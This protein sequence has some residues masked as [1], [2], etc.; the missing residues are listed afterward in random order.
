MATY[1]YGIVP[2]RG[3]VAFEAEFDEG[4]WKAIATK[5]YDDA[6]NNAAALL[7]A[8]LPVVWKQRMRWSIA[9]VVAALGAPSLAELDQGWDAA[10]RRL[11]HRIAI[12]VDDGERAVRDA[13]DRLRSQLLAGS[14]TAQTQLDLDGEVDFGRQQIALTQ[15][16]GP[17]AA[18]VKKL[19]LGEALAEVAKATEALAK[20]LGRAAGTK[21][22]PPS[23][24]LRDAV[25]ECAAAFNAVH[26]ELVWF[27]GRTPPGT[28]RDT[29]TALI[30]PLEDLLAR[31]SPATSPAAEPS[32]PAAPAAP[33]E[34]GTQPA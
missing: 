14:G 13:A 18:D 26:D 8:P 10:Q 30:K 12:G 25:A 21:R 33:A 2:D 28:D 6:Q 27:I 17:L 23:R 15:E 24:R 20:G 4:A 11:F 5:K 16:G 19:K 7:Q 3:F 22:R 34:G 29:L 32:E 1:G 9:G 31:H